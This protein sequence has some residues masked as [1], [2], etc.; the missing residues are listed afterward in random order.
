[1]SAVREVRKRTA[2][3][4]L[5]ADGEKPQEQAAP[6]KKYR[7]VY[8]VNFSTTTM[9]ER[10]KPDSFTREEFGEVLRSLHDELF[11]VRMKPGGPLL[12]KSDRQ[13]DL[14][15]LSNIPRHY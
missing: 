11:A 2:D 4:A 7:S 14:K 5:A 8:T 13:H 10:A 9:A 6:Q 15:P 12:L 3:E 1:M